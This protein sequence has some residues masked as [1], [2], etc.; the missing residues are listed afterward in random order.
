MT[1]GWMV[2]AT[3]VGLLLAGAAI[4]LEVASRRRRNGPRIVWLAMLVAALIW[5]AAV[6]VL[7]R[8]PS[9]P[10]TQG[11]GESIVPAPATSP[12]VATVS[13]PMLTPAVALPPV[14][15]GSPALD[16]LALRLVIVTPLLVIALLLLELIRIARARK[17]W[18]ARIVDGVP[19]LVSPHFGPAIV[20]IL[21][22]QIVLPAWALEL[23]EA[24]RSLLLAHESAHLA[25]HDSRWLGAAFAGVVIAPWNAGLWWLLR[26]LRLAME[27]ECDRRVLLAGHDVAAY[28]TLLL[29]IGRR[30]RGHSLLATG[31]AERRS[32]L[33]TRIIAMTSAVE[34][35]QISWRLVAGGAL[36]LGACMLGPSKGS[37][38]IHFSLAPGVADSLVKAERHL[39]VIGVAHDLPIA[40][41]LDSA[42]VHELPAHAPWCPIGLVD[43]RDGT[44]LKREAEEDFF[45]P[46]PAGVS[47]Q[48]RKSKQIVG[49][50]SVHPVGRYGVDSTQ[51]LRVGCANGIAEP[52][53]ATGTTSAGTNLP[54]APQVRIPPQAV[55]ATL[56]HYPVPSNGEPFIGAA[57]T[58]ST[59][60]VGDRVDLVTVTWFPRRL[61]DRLRR[62]PIISGPEVA[63]V[64]NHQGQFQQLAGQG[65]NASGTY[66]QYLFWREVPVT[67]V[68]RLEASPALLTYVL[69]SAAP[70]APEARVVIKSEPAVLV[71]RP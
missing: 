44:A 10:L 6:G 28:G 18:E 9:A 58:R 1:A 26:R 67:R 71:V 11:R 49:Y 22:P 45:E 8:V 55:L 51:W 29:E 54:T 70:F 62:L 66:D 39:K 31:F 30:A 20:G 61:R 25:S 37:E 33:R 23:P 59:A 64:S 47:R 3:C 60:R 50:Y 48:D 38:P 7:S 41:R 56:D 42:V 43:D 13:A 53:V 14:V 57:F 68:G 36:V 4:L 34:P 12:V 15:L 63:G 16:R 52:G 65:F 2:Y 35:G 17:R 19:V 24:Q 69:P 21:A 32:M 40:F 27:L 5:P 46:L